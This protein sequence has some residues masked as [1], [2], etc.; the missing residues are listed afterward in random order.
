VPYSEEQATYI[1]EKLNKIGVVY[2][3]LVNHSSMGAPEVKASVVEKIRMAFKGSLILSGGY[4]AN[5]A[6]N[7]LD[8]GT[9]QLIAFGRPYISNP[10]LPVK[11]KTGAE[12]TA[13][14]FSTFYTADAKGYTDYATSAILA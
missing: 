6:E 7:D 14:D 1:A 4:D 9:G 13:P 12:L 11:L 2:I 10:D 8:S 5:R 3:H